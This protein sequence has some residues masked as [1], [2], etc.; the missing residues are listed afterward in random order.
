MSFLLFCCHGRI[1]LGFLFFVFIK[2][3]FG[4]LAFSH[5]LHRYHFTL[6]LRMRRDEGIDTV[7]EVPGL[8]LNLCVCVCVC[9][10]VRGCL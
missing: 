3:F 7:D 5:R 8:Y 10:C 2:Y 9:V 6:G 1:T 4:R